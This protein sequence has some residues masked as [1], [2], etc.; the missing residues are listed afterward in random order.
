[1][2]KYLQNFTKYLFS[3]E[4]TDT[5]DNNN[6]DLKISNNI[7]LTVK[8]INTEKTTIRKD[9]FNNNYYFKYLFTDN[10]NE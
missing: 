5:S 8:P 3:S 4:D 2:Y 10:N 6:L 9:L 1:M 7:N